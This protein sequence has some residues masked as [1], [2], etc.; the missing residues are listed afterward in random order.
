MSDVSNPIEPRCKA[1]LL[2]ERTILEEGTR[3][4]SLINVFLGFKLS[5]FPGTTRPFEL[6]LQLTDAEGAYDLTVNVVDLSSG[7]VIAEIPP[8][9]FEVDD[10]LRTSHIVFP[11][12][13]IPLQRP[14]AYDVIVLVDG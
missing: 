5:A 2:C 3:N 7:N 14:G 1:I 4:V 6:Y 13:E 10:R 9:H 12:S 8:Y 11:L